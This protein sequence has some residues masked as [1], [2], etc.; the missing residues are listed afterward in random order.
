[1]AEDTWFVKTVSGDRFVWTGDPTTIDASAPVY[2]M[3]AG[4]VLVNTAHVE[5]F[6]ATSDWSGVSAGHSR[7]GERF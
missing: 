4:G 5:Y 3:C 7:G 6:T 2:L 1:M